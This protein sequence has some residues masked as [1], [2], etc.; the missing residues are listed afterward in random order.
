MDRRSI[1]LYSIGNFLV[2]FS[3]G[4]YYSISRPY[5]GIDLGGGSYW[6][7]VL[8]G[9]EYGTFIASILWGAIAD[10]FGRRNIILLAILGALPLYMA[11]QARDPATIVVLVGLA[12]IFWSIGF[13]PAISAVLVDKKNSG[14]NYAVY[15][16]GGS[17]GWG[18]GTALSWPLY[19]TM[20]PL[21]VSIIVS[22]TYGAGFLWFYIFYPKKS[23]AY[24]KA[25]LKQIVLTGFHS[26]KYFTLA[27]ILGSTAFIAGYNVLSIS[28]E[29]N[30]SRLIGPVIGSLNPRIFYGIFYGGIPAL[31]GIPTRVLAGLAVS[32]YEPS[33]VFSY[34]MI[35]YAFNILIMWL[36]P[37]LIFVLI[38]L[39]PVY[40]FYDTSMYV[41]ASIRIRGIEATSSGIIVMAQSIAGLLV[42]LLSLVGLIGTSTLLLIT[43]EILFTLSVIV[44]RVEKRNYLRLGSNAIRTK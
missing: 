37:P 23:T 14:R 44:L 36:S 33:K 32:K 4:I 27:V 10:R 13:S 7:L 21:M 41:G 40:P 11:L 25:G 24:V 5:V 16:L 2:S 26:L 28:L 42:A 18:L 35:A 8:S 30:V 29:N 43:L 19:Y 17:I 9:V 6:I 3:I 39:I 22:V 31:L 1:I 20:G 34:T 38:W 12:F 15:G